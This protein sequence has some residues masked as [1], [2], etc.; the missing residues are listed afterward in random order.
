MRLKMES[1]KQELDA[2]RKERLHS[3]SRLDKR[4]HDAVPRACGRLY[5]GAGPSA[6]QLRGRLLCSPLPPQPRRAVWST[7]TQAAGRL[8][9]EGVR[10]C[11]CVLT[12]CLGVRGVP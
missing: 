7:T 3:H 8:C 4:Q 2:H 6:G 1:G 9:R 12:R 11:V 5:S 10:V